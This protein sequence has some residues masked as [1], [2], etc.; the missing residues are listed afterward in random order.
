MDNE[1]ILLETEDAMQ[2]ATD[3]TLHEF[4]SVRTGKASPA[5]VEGIDIHIQAYGTNMKLKSLASI[6]TPDSRLICVTP[7]DPTTLRDI[8]R[9]LKES[10]L[11]IM[12]AVDGKLI[13]LPIPELTGERRRDMVKMLKG[14]AED[15]RVRIRAVR[16]DGMEALKKAEKDGSIT[17]DDLRR[18]EEDIQ[19]LTDKYVKEIDIHMAKKE[20]EIMTV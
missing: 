6:T 10:K 2:K 3:Y 16:R 20:V 1:M 14:M 8:E 13:R 18:G 15:G 19:E 9:G 4:S 11:G 7:F 5:L 17:E 12:P